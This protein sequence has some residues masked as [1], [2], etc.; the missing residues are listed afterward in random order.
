MVKKI[1]D[2]AVD[3]PFVIPVLIKSADVRLTKTN[4]QYLALT[5][6][7]KSGQIDGKYWDVTPQMIETFTAGAVVTL[8][9][10]REIY[11]NTPQVKIT[12]LTVLPNMS[13]GAFIERAPLEAEEIERQ[14]NEAL[15]WITDATLARLVR[16][17]YGKHKTDFYEYPAAKKNHHTYIGGL[18]YHTVTMLQLGKYIASVYPTINLSLLTAGILLHDIG[19]VKELSGSVG[20]EYTLAGNLLGH[21]VMM[22]DEITKACIALDIDDTQESVVLLKHVVLAHHGKLEYGSP[23]APKLIEAEMIHYIDMIDATMNMLDTALQ[24]TD[25][26]SFSEKIYALG[27]RSFYRQNNDIQQ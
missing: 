8:S 13:A 2:Y 7:D 10:S 23:V 21:I 9:G 27:N 16:H 1:Y 19:K 20:T 17:I 5:F 18:S 24:K 6:Q 12:A 3:E 4:K 22:S 11:N 14:I 25:A 15:C 26:Q